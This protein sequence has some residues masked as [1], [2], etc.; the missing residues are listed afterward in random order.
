MAGTSRVPKAALLLLSVVLLSS[1]WEAVGIKEDKH[2]EELRKGDHGQQGV[3]AKEGA[4]EHDEHAAHDGGEKPKEHDAAKT[5]E[6]GSLRGNAKEAVPTDI[7]ADVMLNR[8]YF[9]TL[10]VVFGLLVVVLT[11]ASG[12]EL[13]VQSKDEFMRQSFD[14]CLR[15]VS[16]MSFILLCFNIVLH[17]DIASRLEML[18]SNIPEHLQVIDV[19]MQVSFFLLCFFIVFCLCIAFSVSRIVKFMRKCDEADILT[20][21]KEY[22]FVCSSILSLDNG[23]LERAKYLVTRMEFSEEA[24]R[25]GFQENG[26]RYFYDYMRAS[27]MKTSMKFTRVSRGSFVVTLCV[28]AIMRLVKKVEIFALLKLLMYIN[29]MVIFLLTARLL[30][31]EKKLYPNELSQYLLLKLNIG[32]IE[33][34]LRPVYKQNDRNSPFDQAQDPIYDLT[35]AEA[36]ERIFWFGENGPA[37]LQNL[38]EVF[39]FCQLILLSVW[40]YNVKNQPYMAFRSFEDLV[41]LFLTLTIIIWLPCILYSLVVV[42]RCGGLIDRDLLE[43]VINTSRIEDSKHAIQLIDVLAVESVR[44]Y[45]ERGGEESWKALLGKHKT[46]PDKV[47]AQVATEWDVLRNKYDRVELDQVSK[48]IISQLPGAAVCSKRQLKEFIKLFM[49]GDGRTLNAEEFT[50]LG[51][52]IKNILVNPLDE[53]YLADLF[54]DRYDIPWKSPCGIHMNNFDIILKNLNLKWT[55]TSQR[56]FLEFIGCG[57]LEGLS[58]EYFVKQLEQVQ[59]ACHKKYIRTAH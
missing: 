43:L 47:I 4:K 40:L 55:V 57:E 16:L 44:N 21:A 24:K 33:D 5:E 22:D 1:S 53:A 18:F 59:E 51:C 48:Y 8:G 30:S 36:H 6:K 9:N 41:P 25:H 38:Y 13:V 46:L 58:P 12:V 28:L 52:V 56:H 14:S 27:V 10:L 20:T 17:T 54:Q 26:S 29:S 23:V 45:L 50:A 39:F 2:K 34:I 42:S 32:D 31:L 7:T 15:Q 35:S 49:R 37:V 11:L 3:L 19:I